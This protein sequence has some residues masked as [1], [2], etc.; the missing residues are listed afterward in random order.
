MSIVRKNRAVDIDELK[1]NEILKFLNEN[2]EFILHD[3][4]VALKEVIKIQDNIVDVSCGVKVIN[5]KIASLTNGLFDFGIVNGCFDCS[6]CDNLTSLEGTPKKVRGGFYCGFCKK[7][8]SLKGAPEKVGDY[9]DCSRCKN[10]NSLKGGPKYV[11]GYFDCSNCDNLSS[12]EG[13][14]KEVGGTFYCDNCNNLKSLEGAPKV[15]KGEF[16]HDDI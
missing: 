16:I 9:F 13:S 6:N 1:R 12:L 10:L 2:Y 11:A 8:E 7:L 3:D 4:S 15:I 14:P 5:N